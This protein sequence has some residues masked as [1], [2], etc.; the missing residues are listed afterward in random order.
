MFAVHMVVEGKAVGGAVGIDIKGGRQETGL[1]P[2]LAGSRRLD[3]HVETWNHINMKLC[4]STVCSH[5]V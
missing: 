4:S 2:F 1:V 3:V 5:A